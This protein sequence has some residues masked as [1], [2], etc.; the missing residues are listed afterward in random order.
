MASESSSE[1]TLSVTLPADLEEW[2]DE[3]AA[4]TEVDREELLVQ[5]LAT[6]RQTAEQS[7]D[8]LEVDNRDIEATV[9]SQLDGELDARIEQTV[10]ELVTDQLSE[11]TNSIQRQLS[12]RI[13]T[14]ESE[15]D[16]KITDVRERVIQ[17]KK[18]AD[19][20]APAEHS[21]DELDA[22]PELEATV[23][24]LQTDLDQLRSEFDEQ[25]PDHDDALTA[26]ER[27]LDEMQDRLQ[28]VAWVVSDLREAQ[29]SSGG[30]Q[31]VERIKRAAAKADIERANCE[32]CGDGV[33][34]SLLT[35]PECPHCSATVTNVEPASGWFGSPKLLTAAQLE[36]GEQ[37]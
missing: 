5:L 31:A 25:V 2:L 35:D 12:K 37:S 9:R 30:L 23:A 1:R 26:A 6:Y 21:H 19:S 29:E 36:S 10:T 4:A 8:A 28:T 14:V 15:F 20:K 22:I 13:D 7:P 32:N 24:D 16:E 34:L 17:V 33:T 27:R 18:E 3:Q 11:A